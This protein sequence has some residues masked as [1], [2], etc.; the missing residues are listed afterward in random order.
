VVEFP[1]D[2]TATYERLVK[3]KII[4]GLP[5]ECHYSELANHY[6]LCVTETISKDDMDE[7]VEEIKN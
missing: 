6:V 3:K 4:A 7:L 2:F 1:N 5:L